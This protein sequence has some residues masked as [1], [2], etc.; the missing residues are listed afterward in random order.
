M[1]KCIN[2]IRNITDEEVEE[3]GYKCEDCYVYLCN[4]CALHN[5]I[6]YKFMAGYLLY[7]M[8]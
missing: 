3:K 8:L 4:D 5:N 1:T 7:S 6:L 2:C